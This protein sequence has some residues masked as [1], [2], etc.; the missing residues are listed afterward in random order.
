[1]T[2]VRLLAGA[3]QSLQLPLGLAHRVSGNV[4][5]MLS[6]QPHSQHL[7]NAIM[8]MALLSLHKAAAQNTPCYPDHLTVGGQEEGTYLLKNLCRASSLTQT[9]IYESI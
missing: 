2:V 3:R 6:P 4:S 8:L 5:C 7:C 1:M 9:Q